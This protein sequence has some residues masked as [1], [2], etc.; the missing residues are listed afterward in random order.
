MFSRITEK[1]VVEAILEQV[2]TLIL[3]GELAPSSCLP[4]ETTLSKKLGVS[5]QSVREALRVLIG[6]GL[7]EARQ[8][9][10]IYVREPSSADAIHS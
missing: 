8:G 4:P 5:R 2:R 1:S 9:E 6:E 7:L 3:D 10:G